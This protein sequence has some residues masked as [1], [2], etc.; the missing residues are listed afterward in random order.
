MHLFLVPCHVFLKN[1]PSG[2]AALLLLALLSSSS[3]GFLNSSDRWVDTQR[4]LGCR[5]G[6][7][8]PELLKPAGYTHP[9]GESIGEPTGI[10]PHYP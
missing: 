3:P 9:G 1:S 8:L 4:P 7:G 10:P 2:A 6:S 5:P